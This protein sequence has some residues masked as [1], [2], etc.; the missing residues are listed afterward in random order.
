MERILR[1][2]SFCAALMAALG[3]SACSRS[4]SWI[5]HV[6]SGAGEIAVERTD[7]YA[8]GSEAGNPLESAWVIKRREYKFVYER[9]T[10]VYEVDAS[11]SLGVFRLDIDPENREVS[12][13]DA[14]NRCRKAGFAQ[15]IWD[16]GTWNIQPKISA[17]LVG[18]SR[19]LM[20]FFSAE[21]GRIPRDVDLTF[22]STKLDR[23]QQLREA[24]VLSDSNIAFDCIGG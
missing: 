9:T 4:V 22:K 11:I 23:R 16:G 20:E 1:G 19:N 14:T 10:Y 24:V 3:V 12:L 15:L 7:V 18:K 6:D 17:Q 21:P 5:E 13:V 8:Q 2:F